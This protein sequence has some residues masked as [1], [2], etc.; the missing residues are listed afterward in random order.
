MFLIATLRRPAPEE[1]RELEALLDD[2]LAAYRADGEA[3]RAL[4]AVGEPAAEPPADPAELAAWT[5]VANT[6]LNLDEV[7]TKG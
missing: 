3:A 2:R 6:I 5:L 7:M 1:A 4:I